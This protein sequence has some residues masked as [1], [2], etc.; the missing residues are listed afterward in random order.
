M[1]ELTQIR[2]GNVDYNIAD[3]TAREASLEVVNVSG[4]QPTINGVANTMYICGEV[5]S[6]TINPPSNGMIDVRFR[7]GS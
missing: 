3:A 4:T 7:S 2:V 6:L 1:N 5:L